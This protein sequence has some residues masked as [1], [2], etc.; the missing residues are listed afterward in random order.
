MPITSELGMMQVGIP[1]QRELIFGQKRKHINVRQVIILR[2]FD[3]SG[4]YSGCV[5]DKPVNEQGVEILLNFDENRIASFCN[6]VL[7]R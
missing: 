7:Q 2:F 1:L 3:S 4:N 6:P 5:V